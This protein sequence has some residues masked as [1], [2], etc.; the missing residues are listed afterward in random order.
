M[1]RMRR[2]AAGPFTTSA[3]DGASAAMIPKTADCYSCHPDHGQTD[4]TF[5]QFYP[6]LA[7][8]PSK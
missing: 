4:T 6:T 7:A 8:K 3:E 1:S 2:R 5:T